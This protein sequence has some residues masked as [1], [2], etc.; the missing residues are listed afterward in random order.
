MLVIDIGNS[1]FKWALIEGDKIRRH[2]AFAYDMG[3]LKQVLDR[4][5]LPLDNHKIV[6]GCVAG[7]PQKKQLA[8]YL[9]SKGCK[10]FYFA[11]TQSK[12]C[13]VSNSYDVVAN[14]GV[15]RWLAGNDRGI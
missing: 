5:D 6:I 13:N 15:D 14:M 10:D 9:S 3:S 1:R 2:N 7:D 12:Q 4:Q 8:E 11:A